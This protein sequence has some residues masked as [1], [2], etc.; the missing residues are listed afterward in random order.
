MVSIRN[1][2]KNTAVLRNITTLKAL[3]DN[4]TR[5]SG[6]VKVSDRFLKLRP[7]LL[8]LMESPDSTLQ[9]DTSAAF[10]KNVAKATGWLKEVDQVTV[11]MQKHCISLSSCQSLVKELQSTINS[12]KERPALIQGQPNVYHNCPFR[13][14]KCLTSYRPLCP[15]PHFIEGVVKIQ[16]GEWRLMTAEEEEACEPLLKVNVFTSAGSLSD[17][18]EAKEDDD[19]PPQQ[20]SPMGMA[21]RIKKLRE[22]EAAGV[23]KECPYV[24]AHFIY[25]SAAKVEWLWSLAKYI[26]TNQ[27]SSMTP[28]MFETLLFLK[29][30]N[31]FWDRSTVIKAIGLAKTD[32]VNKK[33][34]DEEVQD[35][36]VEDED[37]NDEED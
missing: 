23:D 2:I 28:L 33:I 37:L 4:E 29:V 35:S 21:D 8:E 32:R 6:L 14:R 17:N 20:A 19:G 10:A 12:Y 34:E 9:F 1:S 22:Q 13:I 5:W 30:N 31:R 26:L 15:N 11:A 3:V 18:E 36:I 24:N 16:N 25:G 27:R 7:Y